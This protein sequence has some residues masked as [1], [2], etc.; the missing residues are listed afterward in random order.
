MTYA[1]DRWWDLAPYM[2][3]AQMIVNKDDAYVGS[4]HYHLA[5][6]GGSSLMKWVG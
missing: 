6:N 2:V 5:G 1:V 4:A 3:D